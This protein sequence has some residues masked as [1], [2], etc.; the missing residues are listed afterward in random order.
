MNLTAKEAKR[1]ARARK[2]L[3]QGKWLWVFFS[4]S[5][6]FLVLNLIAL[7]LS[8]RLLSQV[9]ALEGL[10]LADALNTQFSSIAPYEK[11]DG[12]KVLGQ[13][14]LVQA[15]F[16]VEA[17]L[18][19]FVACALIVGAGIFVVWSQKRTYELT[20]KLADRLIELGE[21]GDR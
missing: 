16:A 3:K 11:Y 8:V 4:G 18:A 5:I 15:R 14:N 9:A 13:I 1:L 6:A 20:T 12:L 21:L 7:I 19:A 2:W 10:T 17:S